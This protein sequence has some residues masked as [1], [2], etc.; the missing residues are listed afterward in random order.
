MNLT[1]DAMLVSLRIAAWSGRL[2][3]RQAST[4]VA[5]H[6]EASTAAGRY[7]KCL[8]P[9]TAFAAIN[10]TMSAARTA[11][12]AQSLPWDDQGSRLLPVANYERYT[13]LM[14]GLRERMVR[15]RARFIEDYEDNIDKARL[16]LGKLFR[17]AEYPSKES[18]RDRFGLRYRIIPVPD[19]DH[20]MA[21]LA[22]DDTDRVKRDIESQIEERLHDA[23]GDLYRRLGEAVERVS[24]R[25]REDDEG[26]PLVFRDSM[27]GNI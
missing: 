24:E 13:E 21:K 26:K 23:V 10:S 20:F 17:I 14:D 15:E 12:Y 25:L 16:D 18:L 27:I 6:H 9:R 3:D 5:V 4:H 11:H 7:N 2:Y 19:A 8:L 1:H 22:S